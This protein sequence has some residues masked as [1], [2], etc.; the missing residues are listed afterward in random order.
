MA[1]LQHNG[2]QVPGSVASAEPRSD[3]ARGQPG[4]VRDHE[5][6]NGADCAERS[7]ARKAWVTTQ[8]ECIL[9]QFQASLIDGD[10][11]RPLLVV[12]RWALTRS[13]TDI[14]EARA[15]LALVTGRAA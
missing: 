14:A 9:A 10:D 2:A 4:N 13:F 3:E 11:G 6:I 7:A 5:T 12:S 8:A 1:A 15:W